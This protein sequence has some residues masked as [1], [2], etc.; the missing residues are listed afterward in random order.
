MDTNIG[1][2]ELTDNQMKRIDQV[3]HASMVGLG[4]WVET[5]TFVVTSLE[6][7]TENDISEIKALLLALSDTEWVRPKTLEER[8]TDLEA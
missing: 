1:I 2:V 7:L 4:C 8:I 3:E 6:A 5:K